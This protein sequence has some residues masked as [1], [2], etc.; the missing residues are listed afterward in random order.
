[1]C[2]C[3]RLRGERRAC[4]LSLQMSCFGHQLATNGLR[5]SADAATEIANPAAHPG[6]RAW[7]L[8]A[9]WTRGACACPR[10]LLCLRD[11]IHW[12]RG[13]LK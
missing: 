4:Y 8:S 1:M 10:V 3:V 6:G 5:L 13:V 2:L 11:V 9:S 12:R 7:A